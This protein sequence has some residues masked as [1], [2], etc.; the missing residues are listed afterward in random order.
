M[1]IYWIMGI[2]VFIIT[3]IFIGICGGIIYLIYLP[4]RNQL[5]KTEKLTKNRSKQINRIYIIAIF[6][7]SIIITY[8]AF[9]PSESFYEEEFKQVTLREIP[10]SAEFVSKTSSYP[11]FHGD[12]C[13]SSQIKL[14]KEDYQ[15]LLNELKVDQRIIQNGQSVG[16]E[17]FNYTLGNK[18][19]KNFTTSFIREIP[20]EEDHYMYI[21]FYNDNETIFVN[22]C[23]T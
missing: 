6:L 19:E 15:K 18:T 11:D 4:I 14:S 5:L 22:V 10:K 7:I 9:F 16:F 21:A 3:L 20:G 23:V 17:E 1:G 12:Y 8:D 2:I 13:S